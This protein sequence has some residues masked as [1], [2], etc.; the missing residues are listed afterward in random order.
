MGFNG[1]EEI[2]IHPFFASID[3]DAMYRKQINPPIQKLELEYTP[4]NGFKDLKE[5]KGMNVEGF[6]YTP[7]SIINKN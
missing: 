6:T 7:D 5:P 1:I 4:C 2:K 3:W